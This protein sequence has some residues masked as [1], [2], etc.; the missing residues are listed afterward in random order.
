M[1]YLLDTNTCIRYLNG[2]SPNVRE[3]LQNIPDS[4]IAIS[5]ITKAEMYTGSARSQTP[6]R[7]RARQDAFFVRFDTLTFDDAAANQYGRIRAALEIAGTPIGPYDLQIA[8]IA[9]VHGLIVV[10]HNI[11]EFRRVPNLIV[12]DWEE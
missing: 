11:S 6:E 2:R 3:Y 4:E 10:T 12:E 1:K 9:A 7:S 5:T 8:A